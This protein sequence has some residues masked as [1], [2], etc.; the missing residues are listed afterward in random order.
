MRNLFF[1]IILIVFSSCSSSDDGN[2]NDNNPSPEELYFPPLNSDTW[3]TVS[4]NELGWDTTGEQPLYDLLDATGTKAFI[5]LKDGKIVI[6]RYGNGAT[7]STNLVWNSAAKTLSA[8]TIGI[9]Q[10]EGFLDINNPS[11]M[12]LGNNWSSLTSEQETNITVWN[13]L[14]M[15]T[16]IDYNVPNQHCTDADCLNY[17]NE[18]GTFW[19]YHNACY[20]LTHNIVEGAVNDGFSTYFNSKLR[21]RIG[22]QGTWLP[23][24]YVKLY[25]STARSMARFGLLNLNKGVWEETPIL[26]DLNYFKQLTSERLIGKLF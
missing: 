6:E 4:I 2:S 26:N 22:M 5:V 1:I 25:F 7:A 20:T 17:L 10:E 13:H 23:I 21:D 9:A 8:F 18:P 12:Y 15:T 16:G 24:G 3:E 14:T 11:N 19:Y